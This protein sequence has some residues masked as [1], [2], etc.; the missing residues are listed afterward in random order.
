[1][2]GFL[3]GIS[4][5]TIKQ[6]NNSLPG[7]MVVDPDVLVLLETGSDRLSKIKNNG[8]FLV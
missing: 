3:D 7:Q 4:Q 8:S 6:F 2:Q 1:M 5:P